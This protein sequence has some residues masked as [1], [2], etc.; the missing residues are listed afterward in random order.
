M[1]RNNE[2]GFTLLELM[3]S[4]ALGLIIV[5]AATQLFLTGLM[6]VNLQKAM[7]DIQDSSNFGINYI[8]TDLR[9]S[10]Y[11]ADKPEITNSTVYG[12][13]VLSSANF[14][15]DL[16]SLP[17]AD[18][19]TKSLSESTSTAKTNTAS[20]QLTV[21]FYADTETF[22]CEGNT[23]SAGNMVVQRYFI[24]DGNLLCDAGFYPKVKP[25]EKD[26]DD[27]IKPYV[28]SGLNSHAQILMKNVEYMRILLAVSVDKVPTD[29]IANDPMPANNIVQK[30]FR[31][32]DVSD[33]PK[34]EPFPRVRGIQLGVLV[35][36]NDSVR[37]SKE[38][39]DKNA[40]SFNVLDKNISLKTKDS[41]F[42]RQVVTQ[43]IALRNA[44]G[45]SS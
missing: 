39:T 29:N 3:I 33:Y 19:M 21:Q 40:A 6:S 31:Y 24:Q 5:A 23:I 12:G 34:T 4:L 35:R 10:N 30:N 7:A 38:L 18:L 16:N 20:D 9:K 44:M 37:I 36:A 2:S 17:N 41:K 32:I 11:N 14:P 25:T 8:T 1:G 43:T 42:L 27:V 45:A 15:A 13:I 22:D 28:L 26:K